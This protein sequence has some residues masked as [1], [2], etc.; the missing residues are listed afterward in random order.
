MTTYG[1]AGKEVVINSTRFPL[2]H[3]AR[4]ILTAVMPEKTVIGDYGVET[5][6]NIS[7]WSVSN[8]RGGLLI[9][10]MRSSKDNDRYWWSDC[11]VD[12]RRHIKLPKLATQITSPTVPSITDGELDVW[13]DANNLTN[14]TKSGGAT[15]ARESITKY[16][17]SYSAK[18][19]ESGGQYIEQSLSS[20]TSWRSCYLTV[21]VWCYADTAS[22]AR[23]AIVDDASTSYSS[24][25]TGGSS[26]ERL[27]VSRTIDAS[28]TYVKVQC[29]T[30]SSGGVVDTYYDLVEGASTGTT[31]HFCNFNGYL[32]L[33]SG[34]TL[35]KMNSGGTAFVYIGN[36]RD[37]I[38]DL[39]SSLNNC[40]YIYSGDSEHYH[41]LSTADAWTVTDVT[42]ATLGCQW[43]NKL[44]KMDNDGNCWYSTAPNSATPTWTATG[45]ITDLA[46]GSVKR[47]FVGFDADGDDVLY[48]A[49][50]EGLKVLD[51]TNGLWLD[52]AVG[53]ADHPNGGMGAGRWQEA[54]HISAGLDVAKYTA[55]ETALIEN[56]GLNKDDGLPVEYNGEIVYFC[57]DYTGRLFAIVDSTEVG[58]STYSAIYA[59]N[60]SAWTCWWAEGTANHAMNSAIV[61]SAASVY[62][63]YFDTNDKIY[64]IVVPR[65]IFS[66]KVATTTFAASG[67]H[68][69]PWFDAGWPNGAKT[70]VR[71]TIKT[72]NPTTDETIVVKYRI[73]HATTGLASTW[74]DLGTITTSGETSYEFA[75]GAGLA[76]KAIQFRF[77]LARGATT[78]NSPDILYYALSFVQ[79]PQTLTTTGGGWG[80]EVDVDCSKAYNNKNPAQLY[81]ALMTAASTQT[82]IPF[83][84]RSDEQYYGR[85]KSLRGVVESGIWKEGQFTVLIIIP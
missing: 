26:W 15:L 70:A 54:Q 23:I 50:I 69:T 33:S 71:F 82:L 7:T 76:F 55:G 65:G 25:H 16:S 19:T 27:T 84:V 79:N 18:F 20:P 81:A 42:D 52:T 32:Y 51:F 5:D 28:A 12:D 47:L 35:S 36:V 83:S 10:E 41:Y 68:V 60:G 61:S 59:W 14:W 8:Q 11:Q 37:T 21:S 40:L 6:P 29:V 4:P 77:D 48:A 31:F 39:I 43:D 1:I 44:F 62:R 17:G 53:I 58:T 66:S 3:P 75:S 22:K 67:V 13:T 85:V 45:N 30:T 24:Y 78:T 80:Y 64:A 2:A 72:V 73:D 9:E 38:T 63:L 74:T 34:N 46:A 49:T 56:I 57:V